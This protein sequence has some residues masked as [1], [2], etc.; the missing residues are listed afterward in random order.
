MAYGI[1]LRFE[2]VN[3]DQ[4]WAVNDELGIGRDNQGDWPDGLLVHGG[5]PVERT[6]WAVFEIW[7]SKASQEAFMA[8]RL[9]A[10]LGKVGIPAPVQVVESDLANHN[11]P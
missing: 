9:G 6:G 4:Y 10:A 3:E 11:L 1:M 8:G 5:G 7:D 2:D